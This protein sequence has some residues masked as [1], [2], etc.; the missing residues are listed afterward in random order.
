M[1]NRSHIEA[2]NDIKRKIISE[3]N[4]R[5][6][7]EAAKNFAMIGIPL[8]KIQSTQN[9]GH[10]MTE[11]DMEHIVAQSVPNQSLM[12]IENIKKKKNPEVEVLIEDEENPPKDNTERINRLLSKLDH[13]C[14]RLNANKTTNLN[15][16]ENFDL[17]QVYKDD[18]IK[19]LFKGD[20]MSQIGLPEYLCNEQISSSILKLLARI[21]DPQRNQSYLQFQLIFSKTKREDM[22]KYNFGQFFTKPRNERNELNLCIVLDSFNQG[23]LYHSHAKLGLKNKVEK[24]LPFNV[25][26]S[27][28][29]FDYYRKMHENWKNRDTQNRQIIRGD[30]N[31]HIRSDS[32][33]SS[34]SSAMGAS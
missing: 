27:Q 17:H 13:C 5:A 8:R 10:T 7:S 2:Y 33:T 23:Y 26:K 15:F 30:K 34:F 11:G 24:I 19:R 16:L 29:E 32:K 31:A 6:R 20:G 28:K 18:Q 25:F 1:N 22:I 9:V 3:L 12:I 21:F 4:N 14:K